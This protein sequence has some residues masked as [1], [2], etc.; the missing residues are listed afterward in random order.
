MEAAVEEELAVSH[1]ASAISKTW[2]S[3]C[4]TLWRIQMTTTKDPFSIKIALRHPSHSPKRISEALSLKPEWS[5]AVGQRFLKVP[6]RWTVF[7]A[8]LQEGDFVSEFEGALD[9]V[10]LFLEKHSAFWTDF[11]AGDGEVELILNHTIN[12][13]KEEGDRCF[14]LYLTPDFL[15]YLSTRGFGMRVQGWQRRVK[16][17]DRRGKKISRP[18]LKA[19]SQ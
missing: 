16:R 14:E 15:G 6:T 1:H 18:K 4:N 17:V 2:G 19:K 11:I 10:A 5:H 9:N 12:P 7:Y 3:P 8:C 13:H